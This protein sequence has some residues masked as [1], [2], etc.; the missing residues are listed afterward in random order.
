MKSSHLEARRM[1]VFGKA[2]GEKYHTRTIKMITYEYDDLRFAVVGSLTDRRFKEYQ[3]ALSEKKSPGI[4][5]QM[6][7][8]LLVNKAN[9]EIED[10]HVKMPVIPSKD[11]METINSLA[12]VRG[13]RITHGFTSKVKD[14][15]GGVKGCN[16]LVALLTSMG[17]SIIQGSGAYYDHKIPRFLL[18]NFKLLMNTCRTWREGGS[19]VNLLKEKNKTEGINIDP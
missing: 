8:H 19:L 5:H 10:L 3:L 1:L 18:H 6:I 4:I 7:I 16:H 17:P 14:I 9:L 12:P 2:K 13:L 15:A 11:C